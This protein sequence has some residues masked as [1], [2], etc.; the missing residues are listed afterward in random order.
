MKLKA[1]I[2]CCLAGSVFA[3]GYAAAE[4]ALFRSKD[5]VIAN[6]GKIG[7]RWMLAEGAT[8]AV[9]AYPAAFA[10]R[11]DDVCMALG[12]RINPDGSTSDFA[13][14][15]QWNSADGDKEPE[16]GYWEAFANAGAEA[17]AQW[18]FQPRPDARPVRPTYTVATLAF[19]GTN[20]PGGDIRA[21]CKVDDL[22]AA[23]QAR[24]SKAYMK[25][26]RDR[27]ELDRANHANNLRTMV[28]SP[29]TL[30]RPAN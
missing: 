14:F 28:E 22:A 29:R 20:G 18:R 2:A 25:H 30:P 27:A 26:S 13:V 5:A 3:A 15:K 1:I 12:Y 17:L 19:T 7:D 9:P 16:A 24:K 11:G 10:Q 4:Q 23:I 8:L 21:N 6:E